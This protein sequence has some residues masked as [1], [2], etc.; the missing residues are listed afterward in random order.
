MQPDQ[1]NLK[2]FNYAGWDA[3]LDGKVLFAEYIWVDGSGKNMRSK[4]KIMDS[5]VNSV[6]DLE[7]WTFDGSSCSMATTT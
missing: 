2:S 5:E 4:T 1:Y 6:A 3:A 7:W